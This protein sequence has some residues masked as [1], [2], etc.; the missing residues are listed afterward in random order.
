MGFFSSIVNFVKSVVKAVFGFVARFMNSVFGSPVVA[1]LAMLV[2]AICFIGPLA[3]MEYVTTPSLLLAP[4]K[5]WL[6]ASLIAN[7][8][9]QVV[10]LICP[11][12]GRALGYAFGILSFVI[13]GLDLY[14]LISGGGWSG[15]SILS[16]LASGTSG[17]EVGGYTLLATDMFAI[18][19][20][21]TVTSWLALVTAAAEGTDE[22]GN[23]K[24]P[25]AAAFIDGFFAVPEVVA[26]GVD[27]AI[28][29]TLKPASKF[30]LLLGAGLLGY[31]YLSSSKINVDN[32]SAPE[33]AEY[34][35]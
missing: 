24:S 11:Q 32:G 34:G 18:F 13:G 4:G 28:S 15:M 8:V 5:G 26:E 6:L 17:L 2:L 23:P 10:T 31:A 16:T 25:Y 33:R 12:I 21:A 19:A 9:I 27:T 35:G 3:F 29:A 1:A 14:S 30:L 20:I 22:Q 7:A